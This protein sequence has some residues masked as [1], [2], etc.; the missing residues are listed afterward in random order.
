MSFQFVNVTPGQPE[1]DA[2]TRRRIRS[3]AMRDYRRRQRVEE[4]HISSSPEGS[5]SSLSSPQRSSASQSRQ[6]SRRRTSSSQSLPP[7][8]EVSRR[9]SSG[10]SKDDLPVLKDLEVAKGKRRSPQSMLDDDQPNAPPKQ[11]RYEKP[12]AQHGVF[13]TFTVKLPKLNRPPQPLSDE[14][15]PLS[16]PGQLERMLSICESHNRWLIGNA[17]VEPGDSQMSGPWDDPTSQMLLFALCLKS[18][19]HLDAVRTENI[20]ENKRL[21]KT[22]ILALANKRLKNPA[23][24]LEDKTIGALA[25]L[26]SY[27]ISRGS[28]EATLHLTGLSQ[29]IK[30][31]GGTDRIGNKGGLYMFLEV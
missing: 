18:I 11:K 15:D 1:T 29:I 31:R 19:G 4:E 20:G 13:G 8:P 2:E 9:Q 21:F 10:A 7:V 30:L 3:Q 5:P 14:L 22:R 17:S 25:C 28:T 12:R 23:K 16:T 27:E 26:T 6:E 24:A